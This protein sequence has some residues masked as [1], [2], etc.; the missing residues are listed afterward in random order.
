MQIFATF[1]HSSY[2]ELA[3][4]SLEQIG[5]PKSNILAVPLDN[6]KEDRKLFDTLHRSDGVSLFDKGAALAVIFAVIFASMGFVWEWGP[7]YWGLIGA[8]GGFL[9]GF[10]IDLCLVKIFHKR[11]RVLKGKKSEVILVIE[12]PPGKTEKV[13]TMLWDH[14][15]LGVAQ[16]VD[17]Q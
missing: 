13:E 5:I 17:S 4:A 7:I 16:T 14:L 6:R 12:C 9:L 8:A 3:L 1:E 15:A 11:K 2:L 10:L